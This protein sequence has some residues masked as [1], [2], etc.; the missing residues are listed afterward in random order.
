MN[1]FT[2]NNNNNHLYKFI[3]R[4]KIY[5]YLTFQSLYSKKKTISKKKRYID[6]SCAKKKHVFFKKK[7]ESHSKNC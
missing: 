5:T 6:N 7:K 3:T 1:L 4:K 2:K